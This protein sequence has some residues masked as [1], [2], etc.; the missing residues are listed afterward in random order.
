[1]S[2]NTDR[3]GPSNLPEIFV[4]TYTTDKNGETEA[5]F[6]QDD[7]GRSTDRVAPDF[8]RKIIRGHS[9]CL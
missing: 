7:E 1:M 5:A 4:E 3:A 6:S 9:V 8:H 2:E